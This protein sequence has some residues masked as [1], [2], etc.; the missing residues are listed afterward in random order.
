MD[1]YLDNQILILK[2]CNSG[3][4]TRSR[5]LTIITGR[6]KHSPNGIPRIKPVVVRRLQERQLV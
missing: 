6:G 5:Q 3:G 1:M 4:Y 2:K